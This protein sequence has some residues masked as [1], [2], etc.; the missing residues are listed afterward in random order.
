MSISATTL[1]ALDRIEPLHQA[2][3][4]LDHRRRLLGK[5]DHTECARLDPEVATRLEDSVGLVVIEQLAAAV[6]LLDLCIPRLDSQ[7]DVLAAGS[8]HHLEERQRSLSSS[9]R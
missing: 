3:G 5:A 9:H 7:G 8:G 1:D 4:L 6:L 2:N